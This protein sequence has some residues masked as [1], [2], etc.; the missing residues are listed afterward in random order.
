MSRGVPGRLARRTVTKTRG[1]AP[2]LAVPGVARL[3]AT[4]GRPVD[5]TEHAREQA[6]LARR[7]VRVELAVDADH[8]AVGGPAGPRGGVG[9]IWRTVRRSRC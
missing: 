7:H 1:P 8:Q 6:A 5:V 3:T 2:P 9:N 4:L